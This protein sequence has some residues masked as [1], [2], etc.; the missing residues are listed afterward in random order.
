MKTLIPL[1]LLMILLFGCSGQNDNSNPDDQYTYYPLSIGNEWK[2]YS[3]TQLTLN[4]NTDTNRFYSFWKVTNDTLINSEKSYIIARV[5]SNF[6]G[7]KCQCKTYYANRKDGLYALG[8]YNTCAGTPWFKSNSLAVNEGIF[9]SFFMIPFITDSVIIVDY[10]LFLLKY[11]IEIKDSWIS[12][13]FGPL[14]YVS[15][16]WIEYENV[17]INSSSYYCS[18]LSIYNDSM[19]SYPTIY[20]FINEK[21]LIKEEFYDEFNSGGESGY[22]HRFFT[23]ESFNF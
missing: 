20:Q 19:T 13:E 15:R 23:L 5:D 2:Y 3:E 16:K 8:Y 9:H 4:G 21:G 17:E 6:N 10:P 22:V 12:F 14:F 1:A 7:I 18:K 11:P